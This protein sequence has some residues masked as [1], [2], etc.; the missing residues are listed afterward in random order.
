MGMNFCIQL[1]GHSDM[2][3]H[4]QLMRGGKKA[5]QLH[6]YKP[7]DT[8]CILVTDWDYD[9]AIGCI[10]LAHTVASNE[11]RGQAFIT[12]QVPEHLTGAVWN[13]VSSTRNKR[14][15]DPNERPDDLIMVRGKDVLDTPQNKYQQYLDGDWIP[16]FLHI[17]D[18][19]DRND[20]DESIGEQD[21]EEN[22]S[23]TNESKEEKKSSDG[24]EIEGKVCCPKCGHVIFE[25]K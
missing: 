12:P 15:D 14:P 10:R 16:T 20:N 22:E 13:T 7:W 17:D 18:L 2:T 24:L 8:I 11:E 3:P 25:I 4:F 23:T 5:K 6:D 19:S 21:E 9:E 1:V